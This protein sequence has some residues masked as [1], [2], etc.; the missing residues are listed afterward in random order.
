MNC[1]AVKHLILLICAALAAD[2]SSVA[3]LSGVSAGESND[4]T[5]GSRRAAICQGTLT[6]LK[7]RQSQRN[8]VKREAGVYCFLCRA[9]KN[10]K[11]GLRMGLGASQQYWDEHARTDPMWAILTQ[12]GKERGQWDPHEFFTTGVQ[13]VDEVMRRAALWGLPVSRR[14]ALDFGCGLGRVT[15]PLADYF[16]KVHGVD[17]SPSMLE[18]AHAFNRKGDR[19]EYVWN[20]DSHLRRFADGAFDFVYSKITLQHIQPRHVRQY[21]KEFLRVLAPGGLLVFQL[22]S[23][24]ICPYPG[25]VGRIRFQL[26]RIGRLM[27]QAMYMNGIERD[28]V[29]KLL[30][31]HGGR[32][33]EIVENQDAG[34]EYQSFQYAVTK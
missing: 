10:G 34:A 6:P 14:N 22:P 19:C 4:I 2:A 21:L 3:L 7:S 17:I 15:Q 8:T 16:E 29:I 33:V 30:N 13:E 24:A 31:R 25:I 9:V 18:Q 12:A 28:N 32:L 26:G 5:A 11:P 23:R 20:R 1:R 27:P